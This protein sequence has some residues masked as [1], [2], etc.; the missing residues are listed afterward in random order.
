MRFFFNRGESGHNIY[1]PPLGG[2]KRRA[3]VACRSLLLGL[4]LRGLHLG[5]C[6]GSRRRL[7]LGC[8]GHVVLHRR[9]VT[10]LVLGG[11]FVPSRPFAGRYFLELDGHDLGL[12]RGQ[13][14]SGGLESA[15][16]TII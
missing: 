15:T 14:K 4:S 8:G 11:E 16:T 7:L 13:G 3:V 1:R 5:L 2:Q 9:L 6:L 12:C 10:L